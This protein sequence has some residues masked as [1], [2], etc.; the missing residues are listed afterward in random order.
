MKVFWV[1]AYDWY[2]PETG[3]GNVKGTFLTKEEAEEYA[4]TLRL[5][6]FDEVYVEDVSVM[7][8]LEKNEQRDEQ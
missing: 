2:Y 3:L 8:G 7:L 5:R 1:L 4:E 6:S